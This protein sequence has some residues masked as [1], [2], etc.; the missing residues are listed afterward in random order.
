MNTAVV[1]NV[2][3][4]SI[5]DGPG[6]RT[7]VFLK[8]CPLSCPWCHNPEGRHPEPELLL[9]PSRCLACGACLAVCPSG[10]AGP[11]DRPSGG[12]CTRCGACVEACPTGARE[13]AGRAVTVPELMDEI[14]RDAPYFAASGG[15]VTF[16]G[17]EPLAAANVPFLLECLEACG[18][19]GLHRAV[20]T[21]GQVDPDD[22]QAVAAGADLILYDLKVADPQRRP[23]IL[24]ADG[25]DLIRSNL[26]A[27]CTA[28]RRVWIRVP[29]VPG[30][31]DGDANLDAIAELVAELPGPPPVQL[32]PYHSIARDKYARLGRNY[33]L[34][35]LA[36][37]DPVRVEDAAGRLRAHGLD[38]AVGG[39]A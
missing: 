33:P 38:V 36:A 29:L 13:L 23:V 1:F 15:G 11:L 3:R 19:A 7:T 26:R 2:Q 20:D 34:R 31:T 21:C 17:G 18:S 12:I 9:D 14:R 37:P 27:L 8:G 6:V 22:L 10:A 16:S 25:G 5:H 39:S 35:D 30:L 32:L 4:F 24:G 28:G